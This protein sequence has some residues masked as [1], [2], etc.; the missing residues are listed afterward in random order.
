[1]ACSKYTITNTGSTVVNFNYRKCDDSM[2]EYQVELLPNETKN[3]W[4][5]NNT[6]STAFNSNIQL[7]NEGVFPPINATP[8]PTPTSTV[9]PTV[10]PTTTLTPTPS[11]S[12]D[13]TPTPTVTET[14]TETPTPT[15]TFIPTFVLINM[16]S[17]G[18]E[19]F[20]VSGQTGTFSVV[21]GTYP[22]ISG[23]SLNGT[24]TAFNISDSIEI[25]TLSGTTFDWN[26]SVD[27]LTYSEDIGASSGVPLIIPITTGITENSIIQFTII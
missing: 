1:M 16:N 12:A 25:V 15:P 3:V 22:V 24:H 8:T 7:I 18:V 11:V 10:T 2:W 19:I 6:Y 21:N 4:V 26:M 17:N 20:D 9:T 13:V 5:V 14:P 23:D 27:T